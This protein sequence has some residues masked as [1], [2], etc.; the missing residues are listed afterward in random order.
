MSSV[1]TD[2]LPP[3]MQDVL[4]KLLKVPKQK[5]NATFSSR[6]LIARTKQQ[7]L[8]AAIAPPCL[9][10]ELDGSHHCSSSRSSCT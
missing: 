7:L 3:E 10:A 9:Q 5:A 2:G 8:T 6:V 1:N 4:L